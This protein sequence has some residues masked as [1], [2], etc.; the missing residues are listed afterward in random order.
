MSRVVSPAERGSPLLR[1]LS[2]LALAGTVAAAL[3]A[4]GWAV[5]PPE[6]AAEARFLARLAGGVV[7]CAALVETGASIGAG[8]VL[9]VAAAW[10][11][12]PGVER[13]A[14]LAAI[15]L[16]LLALAAARVGTRRQHD[17]AHLLPLALG[18]QLLL[19][20]QLVLEAP[21]APALL[22][23]LV[24]P[25]A[26]AAAV[27][28]LAVRQERGALLAAGTA[29]VLGAGW[30]LGPTLAL[31]ALA[32]GSVLGDPARP[33]VLRGIGALVLLAPLAWQWRAGA[34]VAAA[35]AALAFP[36]AGP[37]LGAAA[38]ATAWGLQ[39]RPATEAL[40]ILA[41]ALLIVPLAPW[42]LRG[43][44]RRLAAAALLAVAA[45]VGAPETAALVAPLALLAGSLEGAA[46]TLQ[47]SWTAL[48]ALGTA[49]L[50]AYPWRR[51]DPLLELARGLGLA[52][53]TRPR[54]A[55]VLA[56]VAVACTAAAVLQR[57]D[58]RRRL[59]VATWLVLALGLGVAA[60]FHLPIDGRQL[61]GSDVRLDAGSRL[62]HADGL[63]TSEVR[64]VVVDSTLS[65]AALLPR[66]T[67]VGEV[68]LR[69]PSGALH[70]WI[71]RSGE[72]TA[73]WAASRG[74]LVARGVA[75]PPPWSSWVAGDFFGRRYRARWALPRP[76][77]A[78][79]IEI[80]RADL[81]APSALTL[82]QVVV[83]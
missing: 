3:G 45:A 67:P 18:A 61:L 46:A 66:G 63:G 20:P 15:L 10:F 43:Q 81:P 65:D 74:D 12:P 1:L 39:L 37:I 35:G 73:E 54:S 28:L 29:L 23:L 82:S 80:E 83:R 59:A 60:A 47:A 33:R 19:R 78:T 22:G 48:L 40:P 36:A 57:T 32:A 6:A 27:A 7:L 50:G 31:V 58:A 34:I 51:A 55:A 64:E 44:A 62:W 24:L 52:G 9:V 26:A 4:L 75:A 56:L 49:W 14:A 21:G 76:I 16:A 72:E 30:Q 68:R 42:A 11:L 8:A 77:A 71:L 17:F 79:A 5:W 53:D 2:D 25:T 41:L 70:A 38:V 13:G 69:E